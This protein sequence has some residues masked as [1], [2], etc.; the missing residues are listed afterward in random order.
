MNV[1]Q[2]SFA[3]GYTALAV[4]LLRALL[5]RAPKQYSYYLWFVLLFRMAIPVSFSSLFRF[6]PFSVEKPVPQGL[7]GSVQWLDE[8]VNERLLETTNATH[9][10]AAGHMDSI[11][12][13]FFGDPLYP[14]LIW[15][16][17]FT[18]LWIVGAAA[19]LGYALFSYLHLKKRV[20]AA[21]LLRENIYESDRVATPFVLGFFKPKIY[22]PL[23]LSGESLDCVLQHER[24]H[25]RRRDNWVKLCFYLA[26]CAHWFNPLIWLCF[27]LLIRDM[28]SSCDEAILQRA[29][30]DMRKAYSTVML[31]LSARRAGISIP[32]AF[33]ESGVKARIRRVMRYRPARLWGKALAIVLL[34]AGMLTLAVNP[35]FSAY[36]LQTPESSLLAIVD[37]T[38]YS[39]YREQYRT[40]Y[41]KDESVLL[42]A[43]KIHAVY[44]EADF[45]TVFVTTA[46]QFFRPEN[47]SLVPA[48][49][50][51]TPCALTYR[52]GER[53]ALTFIRAEEASNGSDYVSSIR[54]YCILPV[55]GK[56]IY[57]LAVKCLA[58]DA[59]TLERLLQKKLKATLRLWGETELASKPAAQSEM[60]TWAYVTF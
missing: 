25:I 8:T 19:M 60:T 53:G 15:K 31:T 46:Y 30:A 56:P 24:L 59:G 13:R 5:Q 14:E 35:F 2:L 45:V 54:E 4:L 21:V 55:L 29:G 20:S 57:G 23:N 44:R 43:S 38:E 18:L 33:G 12:A 41:G 26:L 40:E 51:I 32:L 48:T 11:T 3:A 7:A 6:L 17:L 36:A 47:N 58:F 9:A 42:T 1:W 28:E 22:I 34:A 10:W 49:G 16:H 50:G 27:F 39:R 37:S 52:E